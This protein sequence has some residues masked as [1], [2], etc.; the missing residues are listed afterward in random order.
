MATVLLAGLLLQM[1]ILAAVSLPD[2]ATVYCR[3]RDSILPYGT[4]T[5]HSCA[6]CYSY[7]FPIDKELHA[8][9]EFLFSMNGTLFPHMTLIRADRHN[10]TNKNAICS[11][12]NKDECQRWQSCCQKAEDCCLKT[13]YNQPDYDPEHFKETCPRTWDG[14]GCWE[15]TPASTTVSMSCPLFITHVM[16]SLHAHKECTEN[17]TWWKDPISGK[18]WTDY[19]TCLDLKNFK[20]QTILSLACNVASLLALI[21]SII[22]FLA[23]RGLR[24]QHR[25]RL[26]IHLFLSF[27]LYSIINL[28]WDTLVVLDRLESTSS[29]DSAMA[30]NTVGCRILYVLSRYSRSTNFLWMF[31]EAYFLHQLIVKAFEPPRSLWIFYLIGWGFPCIPVCIY[32]IL[33]ALHA[34]ESCWVGNMAVWEWLIYVP[35]LLSLAMN[36]V[37]L[38]NILRI[39]LTQLQSHPNEPSSYRRALKATAILVPLFGLQLL[40]IIYR[41]S[42]QSAFSAQYEILAAII[43]NS[44]GL[45]VA[46]ILCL[47][48]GEVLSH[49]RRTCASS[50]PSGHN[51]EP[52][53]S[54][55]IVTE[56]EC[57]RYSSRGSTGYQASSFDSETKAIQYHWFRGAVKSPSATR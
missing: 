48:N 9:K 7:L 11:T 25:V 24:S 44:Q 45:L 8:H 42:P 32:S 16:P 31:C 15:D 28:L 2:N 53:K 4:F 26:H 22:I 1:M 47:L 34:D 30:Q 43:T 3:E 37:F 51:G 12:L 49:L 41:P 29:S 52:R 10:I 35:N 14:Y 40:M 20:L 27:V 39:L 55:T 19:T 17:A 38:V 56:M 46:I 36:F 18:E 33:K 23:Y 13:A 6:N 54:M 21:P 57:M 50:A 5:L